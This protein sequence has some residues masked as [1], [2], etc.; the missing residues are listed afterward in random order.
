MLGGGEGAFSGLHWVMRPGDF[1]QGEEKG[2][3]LN[4]MRKKERRKRH[5]PTS[6][7]ACPMLVCLGARMKWK[8]LLPLGVGVRGGWTHYA[9]AGLHGGAVVGE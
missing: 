9:I 1:S 3:K 2:K 5:V 8:K 6:L 4:D 7:C